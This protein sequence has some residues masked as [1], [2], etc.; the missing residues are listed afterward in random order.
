[1][2]HGGTFFA[3]Q[4]PWITSS[5]W[6]SYLVRA[7]EVFHPLS[8]TAWRRLHFLYCELDPQ[9]SLIAD[10]KDRL[11]FLA[12]YFFD[13]KALR[14]VK[15]PARF[16]L[17]PRAFF[18]SQLLESQQ[19]APELAAL[20]FSV[21]AQHYEVKL[22]FVSLE[23]PHLLKWSGR[24]TL[25]IDITD[26]G[27]LLTEDEVLTYLNERRMHLDERP[28]FTDCLCHYLDCLKLELEADKELPK[29]IG[30]QNLLVELKPRS[31]RLI[32]ERALMH[33]SMQDWLSAWKDLK[34]YFSFKDMK[35]APAYL[36][37]LYRKVRMI[38]DSGRTPP[39]P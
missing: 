23:V 12:R 5:P 1:M 2:A 35:D 16:Q 6:A 25:W 31:H 9:V 8:S 29:L 7:E 3:H 17:G 39:Q 4:N 21:I 15:G 27:R 22:N 33:Y 30:L 38:V 19:S 10:E 18:L 20:V 32:G 34:R 13:Q 24:E 36:T 26:Q 14:L 28:D 37:N 11:K